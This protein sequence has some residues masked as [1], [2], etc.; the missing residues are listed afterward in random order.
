MIARSVGCR[1]LLASAAIAALAARASAQ[2]ISF[3]E[4]ASSPF[5]V[6]T[7]PSSV[8]LADFNGDGQL[9]VTVVNAND[10]TVAVFLG[11]GDGTFGAA[12][13][14]PFTVN[15]G[16]LSTSVPISVTVGDF[17]GDGK[18]D[19]AVTNV[20]FNPLSV[21]GAITGHLGGAVGILRGNGDGSFQAASNF[22][23]G[24][25]V[26]VSVAV[27][28]FNGDGKLDVAIANLNSGNVSVLLGNGGGSLA[29]AKNSPMHVGTRPS[30]VAVADFDG[31]GKLDLAV[32]AADDNSVPILMGNGDGTFTP[33]VNSP[34][35][36]GARPASVALADLDGDG[37][38][39]LATADL[40]GSTV[41][42]SLGDGTGTFPTVTDYGVGRYPTSAA[43]EDFNKDGKL[44]LAVAD[45][46]SHMVSI[47][48]GNGNGTFAAARSFAVDSNPQ[49]VAAGDLNGDGEPDLV[50]ANLDSNTVSVLLNTTDIVPPTT[51]ATPSP[52]PNANGWNKT[53]VS[54]ALSATDNAGGSGVKEVR[55]AI[56]ANPEVTVAG[57]STAVSFSSEGV[58]SLGFYAKDKAGN[59]EG[60]KTLSVRID[61]TS[62]SITAS[63]SPPA[64][65][66][67]WNNTDVAVSFAC[68]DALSGIAGCP[69]SSTVSTEAANQSVTGTAIDRADN[70][71]SV[72]RTINLDKTPPALTMPVLATSYLYN[73]SL[74]LTFGASDALSG[75][76]ASAATFNGAPVGSGASFTL[77]HP[78]TNTFTLTATDVADNTA[79]QTATFSVLYRFGGF[80][81]P[82]PNDG[83]GIFKQGSTVPVKFPLTDVNGAPVATAIAELTL[84]MLSGGAP[85]GTPIDATPPGNASVGSRFEYDGNHYRYNLS[86]KPLAVGAW[87][88]QV[89]LDDGT[90]HTV[91]IGLK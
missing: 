12:P 34:V 64:N 40:L 69:L 8:A 62:P 84:Q 71:A 19:L 48:L 42:V 51:T 49:S 37:K 88:I 87:Q 67:G 23:T 77:N 82:V 18:A 16:L 2:T 9:D 24:G 13:N 17:N 4:A 5:A 56:G 91:V 1:V 11:N 61:E 10:N 68:S 73:A 20:P 41:S 3:A 45:S 25:D 76:K 52:A 80:L 28:D 55:Y 33:N 90:V 35:A 39:D 21:I 75:L 54:V 44:D 89:H 85:V 22:G 27:G 15:A 74:T 43:V 38:L 58:F 6:G 70:S 57:A 14:S 66:A 59:V 50:V 47:L 32:A 83:S 31:D 30:S 29:A 78:G 86:T 26:P 7:R 36:L 81:P 79:S 60:K 72:T 63:Q 65:A 46:L 53:S